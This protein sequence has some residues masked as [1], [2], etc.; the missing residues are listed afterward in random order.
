M[1][2]LSKK[3]GILDIDTISGQTILNK[4]DKREDS[5]ILKSNIISMLR[6]ELGF[7]E[8]RKA[9]PFETW[10]DNWNRSWGRWGRSSD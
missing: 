10:S 8:S 7:V 2:T 4:I 6:K 3:M 9:N 5:D 1:A